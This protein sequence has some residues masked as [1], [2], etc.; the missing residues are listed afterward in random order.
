MPSTADPG[1]RPAP[2]RDPEMRAAPSR[3]VP[4]QPAPDADSEGFWFATA[5]GLLSICRC[6]DC[7][8]WLM[9]P[10][11]RCRHCGGPV[12]FEPVAGTGAVHSFIVVHYPAVPGFAE[13]LPY[14]VALVELDEQPGLRLS[15]RLVGVDPGA[16]A[17][18]QRVRAEIVDHPGGP[19]RIPVF[20]LAQPA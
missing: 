5:D 11:E 18:D 10:L 12:A 15:A 1:T 16:V 4:P 13:E 20:R 14:V 3:A 19:H 9:P 17:I 6:A 7:R 2:S 8:R